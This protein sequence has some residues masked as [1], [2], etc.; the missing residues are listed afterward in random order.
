L[1]PYAPGDVPGD[2]D[3][4]QDM[5]SKQ[6]MPYMDIKG[7]YNMTATGQKVPYIPFLFVTG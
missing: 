3:L 6:K 2:Y 5:H 1:K 7:K 4:F